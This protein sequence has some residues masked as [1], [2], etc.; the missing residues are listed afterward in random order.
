[1]AMNQDIGPDLPRKG[2]RVVGTKI[3][4]PHE[5]ERRTAG[6]VIGGRQRPLE[7]RSIERL[8]VAIVGA[9]MADENAARQPQREWATP[10]KIE[11]R[12]ANFL[13]G[14]PIHLVNAA[15]KQHIQ[16]PP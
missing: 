1:M 5:L 8:A 4:P 2:L 3:A 9:T 14:S 6:F 13:P 15:A 7:H 16:H 12:L 10:Q 11:I